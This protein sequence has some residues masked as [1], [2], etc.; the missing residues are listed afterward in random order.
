MRGILHIK[1]AYERAGR[2]VG[3]KNFVRGIL[4]IKVAY[5]RAGRS[6]GQKNFVR[7][8]LHIKVAYQ[9]AGRPVG[10]KKFVRGILHIKV[11]NQWA[12]RSVVQKNFVSQSAKNENKLVC[13]KVKRGCTFK[14]M[15]RQLKDAYPQSHIP[16]KF[17]ATVIFVKLQ[18]SWTKIVHTAILLTLTRFIALWRI[19]N[20][21]NYAFVNWSSEKTYV[22]GN[23]KKHKFLLKR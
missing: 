23:G 4:H 8:I 5:Q 18:Q 1:V 2:S 17:S 12:G 11:A 3:Q 22:V 21:F 15:T 14:I 9:R 6:V 10:Q 7:G 16:L 13:Q 20:Q 19:E